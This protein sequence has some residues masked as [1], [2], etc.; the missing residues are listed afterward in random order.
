MSN[1]ETALSA[2]FA[3]RN[4]NARISREPASVHARRKSL[5]RRGKIAQ[6]A[7]VRTATKLKANP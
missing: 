5:L 4:H 2:Y 1:F 6:A 3:T 7:A